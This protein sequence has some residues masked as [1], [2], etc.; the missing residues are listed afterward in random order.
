MCALHLHRVN[1]A[2]ESARARSVL[3]RTH[4]CAH[5]CVVK[6][7]DG[8]Q[9]PPVPSVRPLDHP[10]AAVGDESPH[11]D[12]PHQALGQEPP[13]RALYDDRGKFLG[14]ERCFEVGDG[15][16]GCRPWVGEGSAR[17]EGCVCGCVV[18]GRWAVGGVGVPGWVGGLIFQAGRRLPADLV[19]HPHEPLNRHRGAVEMQPQTAKK[20]PAHALD[21]QHGELTQPAEHR[22]HTVVGEAPKRAL[23]HHG[24]EHAPHRTDPEFHVGD[25][26]FIL[27]GQNGLG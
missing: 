8:V 27:P 4:L 15:A 14:A 3:Q 11:A 13:D 12:V 6:G 24:G 25:D 20:R 22:Y 2:R 10:R 23:H 21:R 26:L 18:G 5:A 17:G 7:L 16:D 9:L 1:E 19:H